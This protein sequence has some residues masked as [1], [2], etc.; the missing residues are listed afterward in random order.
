[1]LHAGEIALEIGEQRASVPP[2]STL[3]RNAPPGARISR[4]KAAAASTS[5]MILQSD[6]SRDGRWRWPPCRTAPRRP[7]PPSIC[8][9][10]SG[11]A[12]SR[13]SSLRKSTPGERIHVEEVDRHH[14]PLALGCRDALRRDLAPAAGRGAKIDHARARFQKVVLVVDLDQLVGRARAKAFA[15]GARHIRIV[16]LAL[17]PELGGER[18]ALAGS[19]PA[20]SASPRRRRSCAH[21]ARRWLARRSAAPHAVLAHHLHQHAFAQAA[22]GDAQARAREGAPD[23][24]QDR[25]AGKHQVGALARRCRRWRRAPRSVIASSRSTTSVTWSSCIQQPSTW[26]RS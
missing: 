2:C 17:E 19:S 3:A 5:A 21:W 24:L 23:R 6:R 15:L 18:A 1:M 22:I 9:R 14:P 12:G 10:R 16:E 20:P 26:R 4:A 8:F 25:A 13:K 7:A 11:A